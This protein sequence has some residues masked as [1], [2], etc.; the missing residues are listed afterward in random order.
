M[1]IISTNESTSIEN[2]LFKELS[3]P[4]L[5]SKRVIFVAGVER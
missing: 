4:Y 2:V 5:L 1:K 3:L